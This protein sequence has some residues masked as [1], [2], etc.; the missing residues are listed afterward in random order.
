MVRRTGGV[1]QQ[2]SKEIW[3]ILEQCSEDDLA[4]NLLAYAIN[5]FLEP[6]RAKSLSAPERAAIYS[7]YPD[8]T[9]ELIAVR[10]LSEDGLRE[11]AAN[12]SYTIKMYLDYSPLSNV[13]KELEGDSK[14]SEEANSDVVYALEALWREAKAKGFSAYGA[15]AVLVLHSVMFAKCDGLH[16]TK[17]L[18]LMID[19]LGLVLPRATRPVTKAERDKHIAAGLAAAMGISERTARKYIKELEASGEFERWERELAKRGR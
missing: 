16:W 18:R 8:A 10:S 13:A 11:A 7:N 1:K 17:L 12:L 4:P 19:A 6:Y 2:I 9:E 5:K 3:A 14:L 15:T